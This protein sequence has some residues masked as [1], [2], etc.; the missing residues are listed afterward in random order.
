[1]VKML[2][3]KLL[4]VIAALL[5]LA[6][7]GDSGPYWTSAATNATWQ[8]DQSQMRGAHYATIFAADVPTPLLAAVFRKSSR[9]RPPI[10]PFGPSRSSGGGLKG[11]A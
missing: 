3:L 9:K 2:K 11:N 6:A 1:M 4:I 7:C 5:G 8:E 10:G